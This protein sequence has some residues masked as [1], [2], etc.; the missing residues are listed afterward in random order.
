MRIANLLSSHMVRAA[1]RRALAHRTERELR[2]LD[3]EQLADIGVDPGNLRSVAWELAWRRIPDDTVAND[4]G[5]A[6][7]G[8][9]GDRA[10]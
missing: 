8:D 7:A 6:P 2:Q 10:A 1:R 4:R 3:A 5:G 9:A